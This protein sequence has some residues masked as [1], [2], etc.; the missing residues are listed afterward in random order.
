[1]I[2]PSLTAY[3][4]QKPSQYS[5]TTGQS[6]ANILTGDLGAY[7]EDEWNLPAMPPWFS[8]SG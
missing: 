5:I 1:M 3:A 8:A 7:A 6:S 4:Q 2:F